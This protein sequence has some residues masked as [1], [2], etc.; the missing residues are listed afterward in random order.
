MNKFLLTSGL[1]RI[2]LKEYDLNKNTGNS[3]K[4]CVLEVDLECLKELRQLHNDYRLYPGKIN[5]KRNFV[6]RSNKD[7]YNTFIGNVE[8]LVS[9]VVNK[10]KYVLRKLATD[11][12]DESFLWYIDRRKAFSLIFRWDHCQRSSPSRISDTPRAG[13]EPAQNL[14]SSLVE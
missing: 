14:S 8:I 3:S 9:N 13:F 5:Q 2:N 10:E 4:G 6:Y 12:Y 1:K 11:D 7:F